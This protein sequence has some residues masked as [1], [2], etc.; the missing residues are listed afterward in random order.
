MSPMAWK[1]QD[2]L[3][4]CV[5]VCVCVQAYTCMCTHVGK[6]LWVHVHSDLKLR[7]R[8]VLQLFFQYGIYLKTLDVQEK[9]ELY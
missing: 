7:P 6:C 5:C 9:N 1:F 8:Y 2:T 3:H 4:M